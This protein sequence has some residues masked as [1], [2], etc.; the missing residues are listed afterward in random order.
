V[1]TLH[2]TRVPP[3]KMIPTSKV[4]AQT[5]EAETW[6]QEISTVHSWNHGSGW[7]PGDDTMVQR[8]K[9][10]LHAHLGR[11]AE[12]ESGWVQLSDELTQY[13]HFPPGP[14]MLDASANDRLFLGCPSCAISRMATFTGK[15]HLQSPAPWCSLVKAMLS[16]LCSLGASFKQHGQGKENVRWIFCKAYHF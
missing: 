1:G 12:L 11:R 8:T 5:F 15:L 14:V 16:K 13:E 3:L 6:T 2:W 10:F 9:W 4:W 7:W